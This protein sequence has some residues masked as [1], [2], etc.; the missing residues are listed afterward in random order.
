MEMEG[1]PVHTPGS[2]PGPGL[3]TC[4]ALL[5]PPLAAQPLALHCSFWSPGYLPAVPMAALL[6]WPPIAICS[7]SVT[8]EPP[9]PRS[10]DRQA[11]SKH[12]LMSRHFIV[13]C[14]CAG[15]K[16]DNTRDI[17]AGLEKPYSKDKECCM[18]P[19]GKFQ[20]RRVSGAV[21]VGRWLAWGARRAG[22]TW[23]ARRS[24]SP[25]YTVCPE[26]AHDHSAGKTTGCPHGPTRR[27]LSSTS[28]SNMEDAH[29]PCKMGLETLTPGL[30]VTH[31]CCK[32]CSSI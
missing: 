9:V 31:L 15:D 25:A 20:N 27:E 24:C 28:V 3:C 18:I 13:P 30:G 16:Y 6:Y 5:P 10:R 14:K 26:L 23:A 22:N 17:T 8:C 2:D 21:C 7:Y 29:G 32:C 11:L 12:K 4:T 1:E 19:F